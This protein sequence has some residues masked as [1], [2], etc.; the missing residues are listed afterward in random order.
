MFNFGLKLRG[1]CYVC[2]T[3]LVAGLQQVA[4][5]FVWDPCEFGPVAAEPGPS[6]GAA[7]LLQTWQLGRR[8]V[9]TDGTVLLQ[10]GQLGQR[11]ALE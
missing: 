11:G 1:C 3:S 4:G 2:L 7:V 6:Q 5:G 8:G 9:L 10:T